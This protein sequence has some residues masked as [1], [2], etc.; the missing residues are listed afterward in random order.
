M[1]DFSKIKTLAQAKGLQIYQLEKEAGIGNGQIGK[2]RD[3]QKPLLETVNK[4]AKCLGVS[5]EELIKED[6]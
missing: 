4:V 5:V 6:E 2:W 3:G 1:V